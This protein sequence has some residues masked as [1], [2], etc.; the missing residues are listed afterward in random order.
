MVRIIHFRL[1][2][3]RADSISITGNVAINQSGSLTR[4][5]EGKVLFEAG[6]QNQIE[7]LT[8]LRSKSDEE[9]L[10]HEKHEN[11]M[12]Q[13]S[14][15]TFA[16]MMTSSVTTTLSSLSMLMPFSWGTTVCVTPTTMRIAPSAFI[17]NMDNPV[18]HHHQPS[19]PQYLYRRLVPRE[20]QLK[21]LRERMKTEG[22]WRMNYFIVLH[23]KSCLDRTVAL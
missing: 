5:S 19:Q 8:Q 18:I 23:C 21:R 7:M 22:T 3:V 2:S 14:T 20:K 1:L 10:Q 6:Q 9:L 12:N 4:L 17:S 16:S 15:S 11:V 13:N